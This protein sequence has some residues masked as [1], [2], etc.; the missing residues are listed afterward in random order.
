MVEPE[1]VQEDTPVVCARTPRVSLPPPPP[2]RPVAVERAA[3]TVDVPRLQ[4][5][6]EP[7]LPPPSLTDFVAPTSVALPTPVSADDLSDFVANLSS[8][9][10]S[11]TRLIAGAVVAVLT[12]I[13]AC[14]I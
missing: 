14:L 1:D 3:P 12:V 13:V 4:L 7:D 10:R 6:A 2:P 5:V 8:R 9:S 11:R